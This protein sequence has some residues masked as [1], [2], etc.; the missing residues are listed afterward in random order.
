MAKDREHDFRLD[1]ITNK[2]DAQDQELH[3]QAVKDEEHD[4]RFEGLESRCAALEKQ[5]RFLIKLLPENIRPDAELPKEPKSPISIVSL[6]LAVLALIISI[7]SL[8]V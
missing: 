4:N 5:V 7:I 3:R 8:F 2:N 6:S 1:S